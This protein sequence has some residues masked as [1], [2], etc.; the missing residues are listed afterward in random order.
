[1]S[2]SL[3]TIA[4]LGLAAFAGATSALADDPEAGKKVFAK[5]AACHAVGEGAKN[6]VGPHLNGVVGRKAGALEDYKYSKAMTEAGAGGL[7][8]DEDNLTAFLANPRGVVKGTKMAFAGLKSEDDLSNVIA[9]LETFSEKQASTAPTTEKVTEPETKAAEDVAEA[10]P[11]TAPQD[12]PAKA[13]AP[14]GAEPGAGKHLKLGRAA[15]PEEI[16]AWDIDVR[17]DGLGLPEG[18]GTVAHGMEI[19]DENCASCHGDFGEAVGRWP[20]LAGGQGT[21]QAERPEKTIG[22]YWP[23]LSTVYDYVRRAMPF[24]NARSLSD[25][26]VYA[27][28]AYLLYLN[29]VV[30]DEEFELSKENFTEIQLPNEPN[31]ID[32]DRREEPFYAEKKE[33]CMENC[34]PGKAEISM[35]A[36]ILDVTPEDA[37]EDDQPAGGGID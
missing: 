10:T 11:P 23:Y 24:G 6:R 35:H 22:S 13:E 8:W 20:V 1:M 30:T 16:A 21:L 28:T 12:A 27:L 4:A 33:P 31:F 29:D 37:G 25:D 7:A 18:R 3:K 34:R 17:P 14:A 32:D 5:C 36:A 26:D 19:Y 15:T 2:R 9:Y